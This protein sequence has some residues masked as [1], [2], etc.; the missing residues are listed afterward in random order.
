LSVVWAQ[1]YTVFRRGRMATI[2]AKVSRGHKYWYIVESRRVNGKPRP[3]VLAYLGK[4]DDLLKRLQGLTSGMNLKSYSHGAV[5]ALLAVAQKLDI[6]S[7]I[8]KLVKSSRKYTANKPTRNNLTVG[9]SLLLGA[10]GRVCMQTSKRGWLTWAKTTSCEYLLRSNLN[11]IDSQHF[12]DVMDALPVD[13]IELIE[14]AIIKRVFEK[15]D[16]KTDTLFFD[17]TNFFT[18]IATTNT[19]CTIAQRGKNKQH[20]SDLRQVGLALVV[21]REDLIP[22]FHLTYQ[23]NFNDVTIFK[24]V[25]EK[26]KNRMTELKLDLK[27]HTMVF[28]RGNNSKNNLE[29]VS[30]AGL[31]YVGALSPCHHTVLVDAALGNMN[32]CITVGKKD[33]FVFRDK[34]IIWN[35]E[36]TVLVFI[37]DKLKE[38]QI[39]GLLRELDKTE[40]NLKK[41]QKGFKSH[42][43][44]YHFK[45]I[46]EA[47][48]RVQAAII[49]A[50]AKEVFS[51]TVSLNHENRWT[52]N[53]IRNEIKIEELQENMGLRILMTNQH[54]WTSAA[55]IQAYHGQAFIEKSFRNMKNP[56]HLAIRPQYHWTDQKISVH[57]FMCVL[58]YLMATLVMKEIIKKTDF[59]GSMDTLFDVLN[60]IRL[61]TLLE[62]STT[63]G[64]VKTIHKLELLDEQQKKFFT[65]LNLHNFH[66]KKI[67]IN[68]CSVYTS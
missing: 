16:I 62:E 27:S 38:G 31:H 15:Y 47:K 55:I 21:S 67:E 23:G 42:S 43:H 33:F 52:L 19:E 50:N 58:G 66:E 7:E 51:I 41:L 37:S 8:N 48:E 53:Y 25:I 40:S 49:S 5:A 39:R 10:I 63:P 61:A 24:S 12:W 64:P 28:D 68:G 36:R 34:R 56:Y 57:F 13:K 4:A 17:T 29:M 60:N 20:R 65:A 6:A 26:I 45:S 30:A 44:A 22:L 18:Y 46:D 35:E 11:G 9:M 54:E 1:V 3:I 59:R 32:D 14:Q 2:Q